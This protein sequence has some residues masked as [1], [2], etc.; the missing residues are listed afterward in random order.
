[1]KPI[2]CKTYFELDPIRDRL[3]VLYA[4]AGRIYRY[5]Q[6]RLAGV[7]DVSL[8]DEKQLAIMAKYGRQPGAPF[9]ELVAKTLGRTIDILEA[10]RRSL[11]AAA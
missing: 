10:R 8:L 9:P 6:S 1:M 2:L 7:G 5:E 11:E 3:V 4:K